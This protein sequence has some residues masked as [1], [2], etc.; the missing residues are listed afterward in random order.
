MWRKFLLSLLF[1]VLVLTV[2]AL[3][4]D[5]PNVG[6]A[7]RRFPLAYVPAVLGL[8]LWNYALRFGKWHLYLRTLRIPIG[9][10]DSLGI[11]LCGLS[12][13]ITPG[14]AGELLKSVLLRRRVGT[15]VSVSA[16]VIFAERL[17]DGLAM[18]GLAATGLVLYQQAVRPML[19][20]LAVFV[21]AIVGLQLPAVRDRV[22]PWLQG[23]PKLAKW[24]ESMGRLHA[25]ARLLLS[26]PLLLAA[27]AI[28]LL[29]WSGECLAFYLVL[30]G[31]GFSGGWTLLVQA[32]FVLAVSTL[33]GSASLLPGGLGTAEGSA[34]ALL[35]AVAHT[36]LADAV[37]ATLIIRLC[38]LWFGV[39]V[40]CTALLVY[41]GRFDLRWNRLPEELANAPA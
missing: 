5:A 7:L 40:G 12:M 16:P 25:S 27:V 18:M 31:L 41:R 32:A 9:F 6:V 37:A 8:T 24:G 26:P 34:A 11:F 30:H 1:G 14:K 28:G 35:I 22:L 19:A 13:A 2:L 39:A 4:G 29:S 3:V 20:L 33:V 38:T 36:S 21:I 23:H 17:T 10:A 15:P